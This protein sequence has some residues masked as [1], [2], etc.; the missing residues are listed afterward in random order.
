MR[1]LTGGVALCEVVH[2]LQGAGLAWLRDAAS[3]RDGVLE[4][5]PAPTTKVSSAV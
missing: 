4:A 3:C 2:G 1:V 5:E